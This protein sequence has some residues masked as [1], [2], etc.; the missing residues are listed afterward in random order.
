MVIFVIR[1]LLAVLTVV[2]AVV[3]APSFIVFELLAQKPRN[4]SSGTCG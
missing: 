3:R 4:I 2:V 1:E